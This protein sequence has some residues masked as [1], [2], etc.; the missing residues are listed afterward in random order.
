MSL[1]VAVLHAG[2]GLA[3]L[4]ALWRLVRGP[5]LAD[6]VVALDVLATVAVGFLALR[7]ADTGRWL[8]LDIALGIGLISIVGTVAFAA[9]VE[10]RAREA[11]GEEM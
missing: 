6:R 3:M 8:Y 9:F 2:V 11:E 10:H 5:R 4:L 1:L 7:A